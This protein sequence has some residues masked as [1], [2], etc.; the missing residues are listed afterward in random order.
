MRRRCIEL[1]IGTVLLAVLP[2]AE[3]EAVDRDAH[4][5]VLM[6]AEL[7]AQ[8]AT[9][10]RLQERANASLERILQSGILVE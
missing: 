2:L 10:A 7:M 5:P 8:D 4:W 1:L 9:L 3:G 6:S